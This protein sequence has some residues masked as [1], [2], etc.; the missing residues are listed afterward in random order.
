[1]LRRVYA[2]RGLCDA[3]QLRL[4]ADCLLPPSGLLGI[5]AAAA[6]IER[7]IVRQQKIIIAA[8]YDADGATACAVALRGLRALGAEHLGYVV[9]DRFKMGY[10]LSPGLVALAHA[11]GAE[12][13]VTVD[14]GIA[15]VEG[16]AAAN[17]LGIAVLITDHH[18]PGE[19]LPAA[20]AIVN[21][22]QP[23]CGFAS[24]ALAGVGV[25]FYVLLALRA[26]LRAAG[27]FRLGPE[28]QLAGLLDLV[29]LGTVADLARLDYNNRILVELGLRRIRAGKACAGI[30]ALLKVAGRAPETI[31]S[32]DLGFVLGPRLNAAGR[33][34]DMRMGIA[35]LMADDAASGLPIAQ[36]LDAL[37]RER[38]SLQKQMTEE[39]VLLTEGSGAYGVTAYD[40]SWHEGI[41]GLIASKLKDAHHRPAI[42][43]AP[44][45]DP[46]LLKGSARSI[47]GFH[48]RDALAALQARNPQLIERFGGHA[49]AAG[50]TLRAEHYPAFA[51]AFD[52]LC[53]STLAP[54]SL[55]QWLE[56]DGPL[57][58]AEFT[59]DTAKQ[60]EAAQPWG[61]GFPEPMFEGSFVVQGLRLMG[62]EQQHARYRLSLP[63]Q[64]AAAAIEAVHF[65]GAETAFGLGSRVEAA[66]Q[67]AINRWQGQESLQLM[68]RQ[69]QAA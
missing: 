54:E 49:M 64:S 28:P 30:A 34:D 9:P 13:L 47:D 55:E 51:A 46:A 35:L 65:H 33:L 22:N 8:D 44:A 37:N 3:A 50:L 2:A 20:A 56:T 16:V 19:Q 40:P 11:Q 63:G 62:S 42:A 14:N 7:A 57:A 27:R 36:A 67:L 1:M 31:R 43:F 61:Q 5:D 12:L 26:R 52:A 18:L 4:E 23:G 6:L 68:I 24:K 21:P 59:I 32:T 41:V 25:M 39:A 15:S 45:E 29:A 60:L 48:L 38:R 17:A 69:V 58:A 66:F 53:Q 10:G